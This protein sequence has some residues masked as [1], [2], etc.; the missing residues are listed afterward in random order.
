MTLSRTSCFVKQGCFFKIERGLKQGCLLSLFLF[1]LVVDAFDVILRKSVIQ[2]Y[3][4]GLGPAN[5]EWSISNLHYADDTL[6][7]CQG[8]LFQAICLKLI[9]YSFELASGLKVNFFKS[10]LIGLGSIPRLRCTRL[11]LLLNS[12]AEVL[13]FKYLGLLR[14]DRKLLKEDWHKLIDIVDKRLGGWNGK[15]LSLGG[16]HT[17]L[18]PVL[19]CIPS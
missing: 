8:S 17:L 18:N 12:K 3:L 16:R 11:A 9:L 5:G 2:G 14:N 15:S 19:S 13:P 6:L 4:R 10:S 1:I 7:F